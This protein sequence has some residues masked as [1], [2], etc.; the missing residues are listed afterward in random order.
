[1]V[2]VLSYS[3]KDMTLLKVLNNKE[4]CEEKKEIDFFVKKVKGIK[5]K[6]NKNLFKVNKLFLYLTS[7]SK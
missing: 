6:K 1:M 3:Y 5:K 2:K 4:K 7:N